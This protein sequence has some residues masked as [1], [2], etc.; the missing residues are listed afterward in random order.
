MKEI[1]AKVVERYSIMNRHD[2][3]E[4]TGFPVGQYPLPTLP[5][6]YDA[7]EPYMDS[8]TLYFHHTVHHAG[9]VD[10][11]NDFID[12]HPELGGRSLFDLVVSDWHIPEI[13]QNAGGHYNH[14]LLWKMLRPPGQT[15]HLQDLFMGYFTPQEFKS[16]ILEEAKSLFGSGWVWLAVDNKRIPKIYSM[17]DQDNPLMRGDFPVWGLDLW[18]HA[19]YGQFG[20]KREPYIDALM[21]I[22]NWNAFGLR[23]RHAML[24]RYSI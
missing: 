13:R 18:E 5:Y 6:A 3:L 15:T 24:G 2:S 21:G 17:K 14:S 12:D 4:F 9:Y 22:T 19:Y 16:R 8:Q 7:L 20:P 11:L 23:F 1:T 10:K